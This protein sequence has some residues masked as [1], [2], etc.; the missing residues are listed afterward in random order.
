ML[1]TEE[2]LRQERSSVVIEEDLREERP[3]WF[4]MDRKFFID[5]FDHTRWSTAELA[6]ERDHVKWMLAEVDLGESDPDLR[7]GTVDF[8]LDYL[9]SFEEA[10]AKRERLR[11]SIYAPKD[12]AGPS[13]DRSRLIRA[14]KESVRIEEYLGM[15][16]VQL[17]RRGKRFV[18]HCPL[19]GHQ[20][21]TP[22]F[23]I[24][25]D[26]GWYCFGC[27]RGGDIFE[28]GK[29]MFNLRSFVDVV[30]VIARECGITVDGHVAPQ[31]QWKIRQP[32]HNPQT[33]SVPHAKR[34]A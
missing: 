4:A 28:L 5:G 17:Q 6:R 30:D 31:W 19:V 33:K 29:W 8:L 21:K 18:A 1:V 14:I 2:D 26:S 12:K 27:H 20:D 13:V 10:L 34:G 25:P 3:F 22:S 32:K 16:G 11:V 24:Y 9:K 7:Q 23:T 15:H